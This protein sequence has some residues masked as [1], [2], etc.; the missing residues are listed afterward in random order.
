MSN[1]PLP[2]KKKLTFHPESLRKLTQNELMQV[3]G[4][5]ADPAPVGVTPTP[6]PYPMC[7]TNSILVASTCVGGTP[8]PAMSAVLPCI[9][10]TT[11][12]K[13]TMTPSIIFTPQSVNSCVTI[14]QAPCAAGAPP[15]NPHAN[16]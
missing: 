7:V 3:G 6:S 16:G 12:V 10:W 1:H 2:Q 14:G 5:V 13:I 15:E 8:P 11:I 4:A 9:N